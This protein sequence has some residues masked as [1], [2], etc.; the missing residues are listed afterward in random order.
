M[1]SDSATTPPVLIIRTTQALRD[2]AACGTVSSSS[3]EACNCRLARY[4]GWDS[5]TEMLWPAA[6]MR[7]VADLREPG[8]DEPTFEEFHPARTRYE[9]PDAPIA[10]AYFPVNR[11]TVWRCRRCGLQVM[12]Y[13]EFG[14]YYVDHRVRVLDVALVMD[15]PSPSPSSS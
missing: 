15:A 5:I 1:S 9:S 7:Q 11:A 3:D 6:Q 4:K 10:L 12:R 2:L 14:G 8:V 13:T